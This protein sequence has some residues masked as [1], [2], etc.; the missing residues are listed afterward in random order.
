MEFITCGN[1]GIEATNIRRATAKLN[2]K[3][4]MTG[5][6]GYQQELKVRSLSY[7]TN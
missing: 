4:Q 2:T 7:V 3:D 6:T 5:L 1:T